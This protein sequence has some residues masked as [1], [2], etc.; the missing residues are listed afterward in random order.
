[1]KPTLALLLLL[2][3][4]AAGCGPTPVQREVQRIDIGKDVFLLLPGP[5]E[6]RESFDAT[7]VIVATYGNE[8]RTFEA[9]LEMRP[10]RITIV[11]VNTIGMVLFSISYDGVRLV[12][13]GAAETQKVNARYVLADVLLTHWDPVWLNA[14]L[15]GARVVDFGAGRSV[16]RNGEPLIDIVIDGG[17]PWHGATRLIHHERGYT[18]D[19]DTVQYSPQ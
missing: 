1:M 11:G 14:R 10:G 13:S 12:S 9:H 15:A 5:D 2:A 17:A 3:A 18:L 6:L 19:I 8:K 16:L 4:V 7:Q